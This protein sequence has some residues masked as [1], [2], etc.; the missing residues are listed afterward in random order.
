MAHLFHKRH[1]ILETAK[2]FQCVSR[3]SILINIRNGTKMAIIRQINLDCEKLRK[4][5]RHNNYKRICVLDANVYIINML[6]R[7]VSLTYSLL[8]RFVSTKSPHYLPTR[9][10]FD[11]CCH[12]GS[13]RRF[14]KR[15]NTNNERSFNALRPRE[16]YELERVG[17]T[18]VQF[19]TTC[20]FS[21]L[22][23]KF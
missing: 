8:I 9:F 6:F 13:K 7:R 4:L 2:Y 20:Y 22:N 14:C 5:L 1:S 19:W 18:F 3:Y 12:S 10:I 23:T 15:K 21:H 17:T 16:Y 11:R